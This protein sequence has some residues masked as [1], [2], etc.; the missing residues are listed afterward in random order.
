MARDTIAI[1]DFGS[2]YTQLIAR[3]MRELQVYSE[4]LPPHTPIAPLKKRGVKGIVLSGGPDSVYAKTAPRFDKRVF[5]SGLPVLGICYG[6]Q[7]MGY[8]LGAKVKPQGSREFG[9]ALLQPKGES[10]LLAG[11]AAPL[12]VWMSHGDSIMAPPKG[13]VVTGSTANT[14]VAAME[15]PARSLYAIQFHPEVNH[16]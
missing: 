1:L 14:A 3:R 11:L 5:D 16:T 6:M 15:N 7:L 4:I 13:F 10:R 8:V 12:P 9:P 2:Q